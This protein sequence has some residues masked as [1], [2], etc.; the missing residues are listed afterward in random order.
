MTTVNTKPT[1]HPKLLVS[2]CLL[3]QPVRYDGKSK[4]IAKPALE[5]L[6]NKNRIIAFCPEVAGGLPTPRPAAEIKFGD[7]FSVLDERSEVETQ[8]GEAITEQFLKGAKLALELCHEHHINVAILTEL[9]PSCGSR[10]IYDGSFSRIK[11]TGVGV[12]TALLYRHGI[13]VFNQ[14][15]IAEAIQYANEHLSLSNNQA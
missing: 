10:E 9:S 14:F 4:S 8:Q 1:D 13:K 7:G 6:S 2:A 5:Q 12:T 15:Q 3:G 11:Q